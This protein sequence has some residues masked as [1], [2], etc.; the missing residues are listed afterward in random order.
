MRRRVHLPLMLQ[1]LLFGLVSPN[2]ALQSMAQY[3]EQL[4]LSQPATY[5]HI[6]DALHQFTSIDIYNDNI[7]WTP[8]LRVTFIHILTVL[9]EIQR[10]VDNSIDFTRDIQELNEEIGELMYEDQLRLS[11]YPVFHTHYKP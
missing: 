4:D 11:G 10:R 1:G 7:V 6:L 9:N 2:T 3:V 5:A 8:L